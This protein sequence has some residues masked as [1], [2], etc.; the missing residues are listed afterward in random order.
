M[1]K[2]VIKIISEVDDDCFLTE[3]YKDITENGDVVL[4]EDLAE[5][6]MFEDEV[7][8]DNIID[9]LCILLGYVPRTIE[10]EKLFQVKGEKY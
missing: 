3:Y 6:T 10:K 1:N 9:H 7:K 5:S 2:Y 4:T 8:C